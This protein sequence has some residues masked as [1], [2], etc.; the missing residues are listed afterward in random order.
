MSTILPKEP[1]ITDRESVILSNAER[2][3][4][5]RKFRGTLSIAREALKPRNQIKRLVAK[6]TA[7]ARQAA[8]E[9]MQIA[10]KNAPIISLFGL[11]ALL[12]AARGPISR[13]ILRRQKSNPDIKSPKGK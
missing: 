4:L 3:N 2:R 5:R 12:F 10:K 13:W 8:G 6:K 11:S 7:Q 1:V 9:T